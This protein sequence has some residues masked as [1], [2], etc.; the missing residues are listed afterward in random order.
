[1]VWVRVGGPYEEM[2][3]A[4]AADGHRGVVEQEGHGQAH[5]E[6]RSASDW[7]LFDSRLDRLDEANFTLLRH[8][9][10]DASERSTEL[11]TVLADYEE[12]NSFSSADRHAYL[13]S[14]TDEDY[15]LP[16]L[17][18]QIPGLRDHVGE[19]DRLPRGSTAGPF[20]GVQRPAVP[21][22]ANPP[23][24]RKSPP[25]EPG[26]LCKGNTRWRWQRRIP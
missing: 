5:F 2:A 14:R 11:K 18:V 21:T 16:G 19:M 23:G 20:A 10:E 9:E 4:A 1:M 24:M 17:G 6:Q 7:S 8:S 25:F 3:L 26:R 12:F 13:E 22:T 15:D